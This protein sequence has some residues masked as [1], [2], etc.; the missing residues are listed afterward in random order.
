MSNWDEDGMS[1]KEAA[2]YFA[3]RAPMDKFFLEN[4]GKKEINRKLAG[5]RVKM[6]DTAYYNRRKTKEEIRFSNVKQDLLFIERKGPKQF[7]KYDIALLQNCFSGFFWRDVAGEIKKMLHEL[8]ALSG[9]EMEFMRIPEAIFAIE[10]FAEISEDL[11]ERDKKAAEQLRKE[12][13]T[14]WLWNVEFWAKYRL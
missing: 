5:L 14:W 10:K 12:F 1:S 11:I 4:P 2:E 6:P 13:P 7:G 8:P 9:E 3:A